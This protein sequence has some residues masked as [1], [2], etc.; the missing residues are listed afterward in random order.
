MKKNVYIVEIQHDWMEDYDIDTVFADKER[1]LDYAASYIVNH[2]GPSDEE[3]WKSDMEEDGKYISKFDYA[4]EVAENG[5][6]FVRVS[7]H[8][9][10]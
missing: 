5:E 10:Y 4:K 9:L 1:A 3:V 8:E 7:E 2:W 6:W